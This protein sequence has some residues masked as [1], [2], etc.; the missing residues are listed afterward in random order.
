MATLSSMSAAEMIG[1][2]KGAALFEGEF[3]WIF[4][5]CLIGY[6]AGNCAA[7]LNAQPKIRFVHGL[8]LLTMNSYGGSTIAAILC[9][10]PVPF[11]VNEKLIVGLVGT[12][13]VCF[14]LPGLP[15]MI[16]GTTVGS[17]LISI[18]FETLRCHV[19]MNCQ[20]MAVTV[21]KAG[22]LSASLG[23]TVPIIGPIIAG[24]IGGC[25]GGF[26]PLDKGLAP[27]KE[28][29]AWRVT[30]GFYG[31]VWLTLLDPSLYGAAAAKYFPLLAESSWVRFCV[32][33]FF[34]VSPL[35]QMVAP[36]LSNNVFGTNP[37]VAKPPVF[38]AN[39][40]QKKKKN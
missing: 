37:L 32:I 34:V 21:L 33:S 4:W 24:A 9:G 40:A 19:M 22:W 10:Q 26:F 20:A 15:K 23:A 25:G 17:L 6:C 18:C 5:V 16:K 14:I 39:E 8:V 28:E 13:V 11:V 2:V 36:G 31:A 30:S 35:V 7:I 29:T 12:W 38:L 3:A 27:L 1:T